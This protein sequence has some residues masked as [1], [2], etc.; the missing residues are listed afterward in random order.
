[1]KT[2]KKFIVKLNVKCF[3]LGA[4]PSYVLKHML[5]H[6]VILI[7]QRCYAEFDCFKRTFC[8]RETV[9]D[10]WT[11]MNCPVPVNCSVVSGKDD[12]G[13]KLPE[14]EIKLCVVVGVEADGTDVG[15]GRRVRFGFEVVGAVN[16]ENTL[17]QSDTESIMQRNEMLL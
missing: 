6:L 11:D 15:K 14:L 17:K 16:N 13:V 9:M 10:R 5:D 4:E 7:R 2:K 3:L 1:M 8:C 12:E